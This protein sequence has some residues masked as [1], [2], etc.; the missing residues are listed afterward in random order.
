[1]KGELLA[2]LLPGPTESV[3]SLKNESEPQTEK[4]HRIRQ[5]ERTVERKSLEIGDTPARK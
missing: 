4:D 5:L 1:M 2:K 3:L